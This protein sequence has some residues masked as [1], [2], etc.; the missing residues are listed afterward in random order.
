MCAFIFVVIFYAVF[1]ILMYLVLSLTFPGYKSSL[2]V[3]ADWINRVESPV[4]K[5]G[6]ILWM[7]MA[8]LGAGLTMYGL[9]R[10]I[11]IVKILSNGVD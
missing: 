7:L 4:I 10:I 6:I 3:I 5:T 2:Q 1:L 9:Y 8:V 11:R